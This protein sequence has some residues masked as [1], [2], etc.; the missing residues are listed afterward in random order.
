MMGDGNITPLQ[1]FQMSGHGQRCLIG[2]G[3]MKIDQQNQA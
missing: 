3:Q 2:T 1:Y